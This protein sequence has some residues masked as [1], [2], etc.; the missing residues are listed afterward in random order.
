MAELA[1]RGELLLGGR[2]AAR[3]GLRSVR[4]SALEPLAKR[5]RRGWRDE[6]LHRLGHRPPDLTGALHLD[7]EHDASPGG[8]AGL[9][10]RAWGPV[11]IA[12]VGRV[13]QEALVVDHAIEL[14]LGQ[15]VIVD[16]VALSRPRR[17]GRRRDGQLELRHPLQQSP[18]Q[19]A[20]PNTGRPGD[21]EQPAGGQGRVTGGSG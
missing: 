6:D 3:D 20:L 4:T 11:P 16:S 15:E 9:D 8:E 17:P 2:Q 5:R 21:D 13:L 14:L 7:L 18:D 19:R 10:L 12:G 1:A